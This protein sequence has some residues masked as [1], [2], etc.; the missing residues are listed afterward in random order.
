MKKIIVL[1]GG[2]DQIGLLKDLKAR[3][4]YTV[5]VDYYS[6]PIA[7]PYADKHIQ[8][9]T[10]DLDRVLQITQDENAVNIVTTCTDQAL[11]TVAYVANKLGF[12]TQF[13]IEQARNITNK[14]CMKKVMIDNGIPTAKYL[15]LKILD[16]SVNTLCYPLMVKPADCNSS[17]G[18]RKVHNEIELKEAFENAIRLSRTGSAIVE[19][20][21][22]GMEV[23]V[24][25][26][27][28]NGVV[29][30]LMFSEI[31]KFTFNDKLSVIYQSRVPATISCKAEEK[32]QSIF[33]SIARSFG[34]DN[35]PILL[36]CIVNGAEVNVIEFSA[37]IGGGLKYVTIKQKTGFDI[38]HENV[39]S[40][41]GLPVTVNI[42][43]KPIFLSRTHIYTK[44]GVFNKIAQFE[45]L[46]NDGTITEIK[47]T[48]AS[49]TQMKG[50]LASSDR[51]G[52]FL[53]EAHTEDEL[54]WKIIK[55]I[56]TIKVLDKEGNDIFYKELYTAQ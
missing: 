20:F 46:L 11:L 50:I 8:A 27:V 33:E 38:L 24:D 49:G 41:L 22:E 18:V 26:F 5:L 39:N 28:K 54:N 44:E 53:V 14:L 35:T 31:K 42:N 43:Q 32:I 4:Y 34:L 36:Q 51:V 23:S 10:L 37:R 19:E 48:K 45:D 25:A 40:V 7:K 52:N 56:E 3:G 21:K 6:N 16:N 47:T 30:T 17:S 9:S 2:I 13:T 29:T 12:H 15:D 1:A 55:A